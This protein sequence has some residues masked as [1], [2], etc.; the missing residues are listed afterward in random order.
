[1]TVADD[2]QKQA[3]TIKKVEIGA[4][5]VAGAVIGAVAVGAAAMAIDPALKGKVEKKVEEGRKAVSDKVADVEDKVNQA[6]ADVAKKL[7]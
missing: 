2:K 4:G 7:S 3:D 1:M 6:K 5:I